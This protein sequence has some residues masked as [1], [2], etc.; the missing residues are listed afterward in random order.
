MDAGVSGDTVIKDADGNDTE[1]TVTAD[2][3]IKYK[4]AVTIDLSKYLVVEANEYIPYNYYYLPTGVML[5]TDKNGKIVSISE[6][7]DLGDP[8]A[9][10]GNGYDLQN[11]KFT[12]ENG[13]IKEIAFLKEG[14]DEIIQKLAIGADGS[15]TYIGSDGATLYFEPADTH[16]G[17]VLPDGTKI[18]WSNAFVQDTEEG[19]KVLTPWVIYDENGKPLYVLEPMRDANGNVKEGSYHVIGYK[20][21]GTTFDEGYIYDLELV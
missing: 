3:T 21:D 19:S 2:G 4:D 1:Y 14:T 15:Q 13:K 17:I 11:V 7:G 10:T 18:F 12:T 16:L 5:L 9:T 8:N 6:N 20:A